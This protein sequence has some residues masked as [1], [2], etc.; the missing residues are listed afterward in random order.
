MKDLLLKYVFTKSFLLG[1][2]CCIGLL[3]NYIF[4]DDNLLE[5]LME[6]GVKLL[7][8]INV[9]FDIDKFQRIK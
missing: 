4:G 7:T 1:M 2:I 8:G 5:E 3:S 9:D 6:W